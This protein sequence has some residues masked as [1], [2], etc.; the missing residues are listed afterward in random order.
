[1]S[2]ADCPDKLCKNMGTIDKKGESI[3]CLPHQ[4]VVEITDD[5]SGGKKENVDVIAK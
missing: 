4:V 1:M 2:E 3:I 5:K